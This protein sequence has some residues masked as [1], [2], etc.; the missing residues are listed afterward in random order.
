MEFREGNEHL[1][2]TPTGLEPGDLVEVERPMNT[3]TG[4]KHTKWLG[5]IENTQYNAETGKLIG[6]GVRPVGASVDENLQILEEHI[7]LITRPLDVTNITDEDLEEHIA[8]LHDL[9]YKPVI[10]K[11]KA[12]KSSIK[13]ERPVSLETKARRAVKTGRVSSTDLDALLA[14]AEETIRKK[15]SE[16]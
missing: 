5:T 4:I 9:T 3:P 14:A 16:S 13:S 11:K 7:T 6:F 10:K 12:R 1:V 8:R 15:E 2:D